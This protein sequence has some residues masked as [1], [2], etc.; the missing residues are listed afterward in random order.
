MILREVFQCSVRLCIQKTKLF[1]NRFD[2]RNNLNEF[3]FYQL[4]WKFFS[5]SRTDLVYE[6]T[7]NNSKCH[8]SKVCFNKI[9]VN[10]VSLFNIQSLKK[11]VIIQNFIAL[12]V[13]LEILHFSPTDSIYEN[14]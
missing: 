5:F 14:I 4:S 11:L 12:K 9:F 3:K 6:I 13:C 2:L 1:A 10:H 8:S 7:G